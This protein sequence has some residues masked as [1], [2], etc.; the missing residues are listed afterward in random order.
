MPKRDDWRLQ[1]HIKLKF[2]GSERKQEFYHKLMSFLD[3]DWP[4]KRST[5]RDGGKVT[6]DKCGGHVW[7]MPRIGVKELKALASQVDE[8]R[9]LPGRLKLRIERFATAEGCKPGGGGD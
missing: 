7:T 9:D 6:C 2:K 8:S 5:L 3:V 4:Y 1:L